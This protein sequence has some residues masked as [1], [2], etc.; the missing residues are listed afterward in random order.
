MS[1]EELMEQ[2]K[3]VNAL[4]RK[5]NSVAELFLLQKKREQL[6]MFLTLRGQIATARRDDPLR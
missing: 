1:V 5:T 4:L 6:K 2:L 3:R